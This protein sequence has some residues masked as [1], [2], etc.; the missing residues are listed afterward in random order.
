MPKVSIIIPVYNTEPY[1][2][3]CLE[4]VVS[5]TLEDIEIICVNDGSTDASREVLEEYRRRDERVAIIDQENQGASTARNTGLDTASGEYVLFLDSDDSL[6]PAAAGDVYARCAHDGADI[7]VFKIRY[8]Y[9]DRDVTM[10]A[11]WSLRM[12]MVPSE[13]PFSYQDMPGGI[14]SFTTP[15]VWNKMFRRS[16]IVEEE[17]RFTPELQRAEDVPFTYVALVKAKTITVVDQALVCYKTGL[18]G[19]LQATIDERPLDI[20]VSLAVARQGIV[21]AGVY[22]AVERDFVSAALH[23]C[24]FT[25]ES[26]K[27]IEGFV[28]LYDGLNERYF[29]ELGIDGCESEKFFDQRHYKQYLKIKSLPAQAYLLDEANSLR[30]QL[31]RRHDELR[32]VRSQLARRTQELHSSAESHAVTKG[33]LEETRANLKQ[34][35]ATLRATKEN[36]RATRETLRLIRESRSYKVARRFSRLLSRIKRLLHLERRKGKP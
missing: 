35:R 6:E 2:R 33:L 23:Q 27:T 13:T 17:L 5:Q 19:T 10:D 26:L 28:E 30:Q 18:P 11:D 12:T 31:T 3:E 9:L 8:L 1:L 36:L 16:F 25:L 22:D 32:H 7:G 20:C 21:E 14:F 34:T 24:L 29:V 15:A 4:S